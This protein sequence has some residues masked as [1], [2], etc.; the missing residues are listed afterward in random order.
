MTG[1]PVQRWVAWFAR[2]RRLERA[3]EDLGSE[4]EV[5][6]THGMTRA[7][8]S[9]YLTVARRLPADFLD[10]WEV[11]TER[12]GRGR[13]SRRA[14]DLRLDCIMSVRPS[15]RAWRTPHLGAFRS[16]KGLEA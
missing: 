6:R 3:L 8:V 11:E 7:G 1:A 2:A 12:K 9:Q 15:R 14:L 16:K 4:A 5:A 13:K 10:G